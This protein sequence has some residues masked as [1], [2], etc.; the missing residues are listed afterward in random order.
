[1]YIFSFLFGENWDVCRVIGNETGKIR[2]EKTQNWNAKRQNRDG[3]LG[4]SLISYN[5]FFSLY[6]HLIA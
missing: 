5:R 1:M 2:D 6:Y 3:L 4:L